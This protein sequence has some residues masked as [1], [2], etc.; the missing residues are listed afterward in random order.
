MRYLKLA[1]EYVK[2]PFECD[3]SI[4]EELKNKSITFF[5]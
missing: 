2:I 4:D 3:K 5:F 1:D